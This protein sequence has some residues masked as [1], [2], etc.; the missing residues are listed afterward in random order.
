MASLQAISPACAEPGQMRYTWHD[1]PGITLFPAARVGTAGR[2]PLKKEKETQL[3]C[4]TQWY[5]C[6]TSVGPFFRD[7]CKT[8][9]HSS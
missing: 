8:Q 4:T 5:K 7:N 2:K 1:I 9:A 3:V 6:F